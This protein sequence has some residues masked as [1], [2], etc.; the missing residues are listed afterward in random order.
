MSQN[1]QHKYLCA[2]CSSGLEKVQ[3]QHGIVWSCY[4]CKGRAIGLGLLQKISD[5]KLIQQVWVKSQQ[6]KKTSRKHC[7]LC[8]KAMLAV[9]TEPQLG[10]VELD[11]CDNCFYIWF[12]DRDLENIPKATEAE[13]QKRTAGIQATNPS[14][15]NLQ[16][17][18]NNDTENHSNDNIIYDIVS[19]IL[20][21]LR[22]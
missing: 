10:S 20:T 6:I 14:V 21:W 12:D 5:P 22:F 13:I 18:K 11:V 8:R 19:H 17:L 16:T 1:F 3:T 15:S 7:P 2:N 9:D 4:K